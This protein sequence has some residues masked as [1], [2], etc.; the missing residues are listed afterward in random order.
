MMER[1]TDRTADGIAYVKSETGNEGVGAFTTQRRLPELISRLAAYED[2]GLRPEQVR[3]LQQDIT[4]DIFLADEYYDALEE[5]TD[6]YYIRKVVVDPSAASFM[7]CIHRHGRFS[8]WDADNSVL[9][10]IRVTSSLLSA[11]MVKIHESCADAI[12]EFGLYRWDEKAGKDQVI[13][14]NDHAMDDIRYFC[15]TILAHEYRWD[16]WERK[17]GA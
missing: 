1:L 3:T 2:T 16:T 6:G 17:G 15:Y 5:L 14:E 9:D 8:V 10:G 12:R 11:G 7:A 4:S 13:K